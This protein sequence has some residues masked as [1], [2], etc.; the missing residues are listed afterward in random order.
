MSTI[1]QKNPVLGLV[2]AF[3]IGA[4]ISGVIVGVVTNNQPTGT[5]VEIDVTASQWT[6][7]PSLI[8]VNLGDHVILHIT[9]TA[10]DETAYGYHSFIMQKYNLSVELPI[11]KTTDIEFDATIAGEFRFECGVYCGTNH[12]DMKGTLVVKSGS[13]DVEEVEEVLTPFTT[14]FVDAG[15]YC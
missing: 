10:D 5:V 9:A 13:Q 11:D 1:L 6:F 2:A 12:L 14:L 3:I 8:E 7:D 15:N 4:L